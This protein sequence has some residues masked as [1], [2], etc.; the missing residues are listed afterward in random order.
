[1][2]LSKPLFH[3]QLAAAE[4]KLKN[5]FYCHTKKKEGR[6]EKEKKR[7]RR[8]FGWSP[9]CTWRAMPPACH[10]GWVLCDT[11]L[12][13]THNSSLLPPPPDP[14]LLIYPSL[15]IYWSD[16]TGRVRSWHEIFGKLGKKRQGRVGWGSVWRL[17]ENLLLATLEGH[18]HGAGSAPSMCFLPLLPGKF[19]VFGDKRRQF[20]EKNI[21]I[22]LLCSPLTV[23][24]SYF[25]FFFFLSPMSLFSCL[26]PN[27][28]LLFPFHSPLT[29]N[30]CTKHFLPFMPSW[31]PWTPGGGSLPGPPSHSGH[32]IL[33]L[34]GWHFLPPLSSPSL[35]PLSLQ[36]HMQPHFLLS[37]AS[38]W[39]LFGR[40]R[41]RENFACTLPVWW[42]TA[43]THTPPG[44]Q[45]VRQ[46]AGGS[47]A[48]AHSA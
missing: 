14:L 18:A 22:L 4:K 17:G 39:P 37:H 33:M 2:C 11:C 28:V 19:S 13:T 21:I 24:V 9:T 6:T 5:A 42:N 16:W 26:L 3:W 44:S 48:M 45:S 32:F 31:N 20:R 25:A 40:K 43:H 8:Y 7:T 30:L 35:S 34:H 29:W 46:G 15:I 47:H 23:H 36:Q 41:N 10:A 1:M 27:T 12:P 38:S